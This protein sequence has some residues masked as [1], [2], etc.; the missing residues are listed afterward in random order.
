MPKSYQL[1]LRWVPFV[2]LLAFLLLY[3]PVFVSFLIPRWST[4]ESVSHGWLVIPIAAITVW[5]K[6]SELNSLPIQP[7]NRGA[8]LVAFAFVMHLVEKILDLNGPSPMSIPIYIAGSVLWICGAR[9][10]RALAFPIGYLLFM[11]PVPGG[12]TQLVSFPLRL[13]ATSGS[14]YIA[15]W[16]QV[17]IYG[18]G[19]NLEFMQPR[20]TEY[21]RILVADPCSGLHSLMAIKALHAITAYVSRLKLPWKWLLFW[22][23]LPITLTANVCRMTLIILVC[24]YGDKTFGLTLFHDYSPYVLFLFVFLILIGF[25]QLLERWTGGGKW[26]QTQRVERA[27]QP[28]VQAPIAFETV[29]RVKRIAVTIALCSVL[30]GALATYIGTRPAII[31]L[32]ADVSKIPTQMG[33]W[34]SVGDLPADASTMKQIQADSFINR[35]YVSKQG[36]VVD[37]MVVYRRYGRREFAHRPD[38]CFPAGGYVGIRKAIELFPWFN[39]TIPVVYWLFDGSNVQRDD[40]GT[41]TP[42][43]TVT[44]FFAS[45]NRTEHDFLRQQLWMALER[46]FPN[47]NGWTFLRLTSPR[48]TTD[49]DALDAQREFLR[50][51]QSDLRRVITTD[52]TTAG[53]F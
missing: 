18:A 3:V 49:A 42:M 48:K 47:K 9:W 24:A 16:F 31:A 17:E 45:G 12:L 34:R 19:M 29:R 27:E 14:K 33:D 20:G 13:L 8:L 15:S 50:A 37:F 32:G 38:Q 28:Q 52:Q 40:G 46:V 22:L 1:T 36:Q 23:A 41:G 6:R 26:W 11:I 4:D 10:L 7:D 35:R 30:T 44:Y 21:I 2:L 53:V 43:T 5:Y 25:G 51:M 39:S